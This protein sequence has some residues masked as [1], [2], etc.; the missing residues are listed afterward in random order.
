MSLGTQLLSIC[1]VFPYFFP[2]SLERKSFGCPESA[3][4]TRFLS[5]RHILAGSV[6]T[7]FETPLA[8]PKTGNTDASCFLRST[9]V[10][11]SST[12]IP[13]AERK[14]FHS[15][16]SADLQEAFL[17]EFFWSSRFGMYPLTASQ[18]SSLMSRQP[19]RLCSRGQELV[20]QVFVT[21]VELDLVKPAAE[22]ADGCG[23]EGLPDPGHPRLVQGPRDRNSIPVRDG[24]RRH[25]LPREW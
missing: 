9:L 8:E 3:I 6:P 5:D 19:C 16:V 20:Q 11:A 15:I 14:E 24:G 22:C 25:G 4:A 7:S 12:D 13:C 1:W 10:E 2:P 21:T 18:N 23:D 17:T